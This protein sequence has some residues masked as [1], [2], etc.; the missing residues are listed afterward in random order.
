[1]KNYCQIF[2][3]YYDEEEWLETRCSDLDCEFCADRP[4]EHSEDCKCDRQYL[5]MADG[6]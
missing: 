1:M 6:V 2:D 5:T 3:A 4:E